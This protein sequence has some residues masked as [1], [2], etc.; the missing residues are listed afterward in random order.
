M[1]Y[2]TLQHFSDGE[3]FV[4]IEGRKVK[5]E[6]FR[7]FDFFHYETWA[8]HYCIVESRSGMSIAIEDTLKKTKAIAQRNLI[9]LGPEQLEHVITEQEQIHG[10]SPNCRR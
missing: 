1:K 10:R 9:D 4:R 7:D 2:Y 6:N 5:F 3:R 8:G